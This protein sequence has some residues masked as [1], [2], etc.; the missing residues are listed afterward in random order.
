MNSK[1]KGWQR[2]LLLIIPYLFIVG[3]FQMIGMIVSG[4][5]FEA[6]S[7]TKTSY[8]ELVISIFNFIG[9]FVL[10]WIFMKYVDK[11]NFIKLGFQFR[12]RLKDFNLG[13]LVGFVIMLAGFL[14]LWN[15]D[16]VNVTNTN[17]DL[18][19]VLISMG[20]FAI[21]AIVEETLL[22]GYILRN[23]MLSMNK[24]IALIISAIIFALMHGANPNISLF[25]LSDLFLAGVLLG[26]SYIYTK[27]LWFPIA[28]HFSWNLVQS[29]L[30]FNVSG[31]DFY[32]IVEFKIK[33]ANIW[34]GGNF[35][36]EASVLSTAA[37][38][39]F[40]IWIYFYFRKEDSTEKVLT[41]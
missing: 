23:L 16:Q 29:L 2:V 7:Y 3:I 31:Q 9:H 12:N 28:L 13:F 22:R 32:S 34:N 8:Q 1:L 30:G 41:K 40:I 5:D 37:Q 26:M 10:L 35:G 17:F 18:I 15:L 36:F 27:N 6:E 19:E 39:I 4:V 38:L 14:I 11:E 25:A 24:Y 21:V 33:E 20:V